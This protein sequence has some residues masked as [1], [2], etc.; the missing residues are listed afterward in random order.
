M[1]KYFVL[2][3]LVIF[4]VFSNTRNILFLNSYSRDFAWTEQQLKGVEDSF[5]GDENYNFYYEYLDSKNIESKNYIKRFKEIF[6]EKYGDKDLEMVVVTDDFAFNFVRE[7]SN[8]LKKIPYVI[9]SGI[10]DEFSENEKTTIL[11][12]KFDMSKNLSLAKEQNPFLKHIYFVLDDGISSK[13]FK[14]DITDV[15]GKE[16]GIQFHWLPIDYFELKTE[17][18]EIKENSVIFHLVYFRNSQG[19]SSKYTSVIKDLYDNIKVPVYTPFSFY[20][21]KDNNILGAYLIDGYKMGK[22]VGNLMKSY[23]S[24]EKL[25]K[26]IK[27]PG[28]YSSYQFNYKVLKNNY[29]E[30][31]PK[32]SLIFFKDKSFFESRRYELFTI[33]LILIISGFVIRYYRK[34]YKKELK[35]NEQ[36]KAIIE[37]NETLLETQKEIIAALGQIIEN[38]SEETANHTKRVAKISKFIAEELGF[39]EK[40]ANLIEMA[41]P[42]HDV[43]KIGI[44]EL[45]LHKPG[46]LTK[47][48]FDVVKTHANIGYEILKKSKIPILKAAAHIAHEHHERWDGL[49]YPRG[50]KGEEINVYA[51]ITTASDIFDAL[52]SKRSYKESWEIGQVINYYMEEDGK[53]FDP[54]IVDVFLKNI[55]K[56]IKIRD[57]L[58]D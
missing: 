57:D 1:N 2:F 8:L 10:N 34:D 24:G 41:S 40:E 43:G 45:V 44:P 11:Y 36:N 48:E 21:Q 25:L 37:L 50:I 3:I 55:D 42:L 13:G 35:I 53:I 56:I 22:T 33:F 5:A 17:L 28:L 47:E 7:N 54:K 51:R 20:L 12:E 46:R 9:A 23:F 26:S 19:I 58:N 38:R 18:K 49:G 30:K 52:L 16:K 27:D 14:R 32:D 4:N 39:A 31:I 6:E 15:I 29:I